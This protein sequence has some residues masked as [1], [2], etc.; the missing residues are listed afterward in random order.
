MRWALA[1]AVEIALGPGAAG[2]ELA[3]PEGDEPLG[4]PAIAPGDVPEGASDEIQRGAQLYLTASCVGCHSWTEG[5]FP[6][7][8]GGRPAAS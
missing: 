7:L 6:H 4:P 2:A 3:C 5:G 1:L 8:A